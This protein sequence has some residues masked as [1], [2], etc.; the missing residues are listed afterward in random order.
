MG[1]SYRDQIRGGSL[2]VRKSAPYTCGVTVLLLREDGMS[3][4][5][6]G[7]KA[8][9]NFSFSVACKQTIVIRYITKYIE[10]FVDV[11]Q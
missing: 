2:A 11:I 4:L 8:A 9:I 10:L 1:R 5:S 6:H 7:G 3:S